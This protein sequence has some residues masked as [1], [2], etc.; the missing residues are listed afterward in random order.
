MQIAEAPA[1]VVVWDPEGEFW[2][3][4]IVSSQVATILGSEPRRAVCLPTMPDHFRWAGCAGFAK[5]SWGAGLSLDA[6]APTQVAPLTLYMHPDVRGLS[7]AARLV[8]RPGAARG[9]RAEGMVRFVSDSGQRTPM[10]AGYQEIGE[11]PIL[12]RDFDLSSPDEHGGWTIRGAGL[13]SVGPEGFYGFSLYGMAPGLAVAW[14][15]ASVA[16]IRL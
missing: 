15:A 13:S 1:H 2:E 14:V 10:R 9:G 5:R 12:F 7:W 6:R 16:P 8:P 4:G 11:K 3:G